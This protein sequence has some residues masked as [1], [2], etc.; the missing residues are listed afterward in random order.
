MAKL[1]IDGYGTI[2]V[3]DEV[4]SWPK[5]SVDAL[6]A[7]AVEKKAPVALSD[8][9][10]QALQN[11]PESAVQFA[12]DIV[13]PILHPIDTAKAIGSVA[14]G[15]LQK[16]GAVS[17]DDS[18]KDAD[19]FG[20][21]F[22][23][24]YGGWDNVKRTMAQDP[25]GFLGDLSMVLTGGAAATVRAPGVIGKTGKILGAAGEMVDPISI[26][27]KTGKV[28]S[29]LL[30]LTTGTSG[31]AVRGAYNAGRAGGETAEA[32]TSN[33]RGTAP[34]TDVVNEARS[35][36]GNMRSA[37]SQAYTTEMA[38][39]GK[40][41]EVLAFDVAEK[42]LAKSIEDFGFKG[43]F[44]PKLEGLR[45]QVE[46]L[47]AEWRQMDPATFHTPAGF[48][49]L[50]KEIWALQGEYKLGTAEHSF[51]QGVRKSVENQIKVQAPEYS[52]IMRDY[53][54]ASETIDEIERSLSLGHTS[55][56]DSGLRKLQSIMRNNANTNY[57]ARV[58][59]GELLQQSGA[60]N[61][62]EMLAG[63]SM[64][65]WAPRGIARAGVPAIAGGAALNPAVA[66]ML[67]L[68]S[69]R[70]VGEA[71]YGAG[72]AARLGASLFDLTQLPRLEATPGT[73]M[74]GAFQAGRIEDL[75]N[76]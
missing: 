10:G 65:A 49:A 22:A 41:Q 17:G 56:V 35:A 26:A 47:M 18:I 6:V 20:Q 57:G 19:A 67:P 70:L 21:F 12:S 36:L 25:V 48:D 72:T 64:S 4:K 15:G 28:G 2:D 24:R 55:T 58:N 8:V 37:R 16:L 74:R 23:E 50:K 27:S 73:V 43:R 71:A 53:R 54:T 61:L 29:E 40:N 44:P 75:E 32:F 9:P 39:L 30:G 14:K 51:L 34:V 13:Q 7:Q 45:G 46:S 31:E 66:A 11:L 1:L 68:Q 38:K 33:M 62:M 69:P 60:T 3:P 52:K 59:M 42:A 76:R 63:Q 5:A